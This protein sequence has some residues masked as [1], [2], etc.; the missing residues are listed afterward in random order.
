MSD[1]RTSSRISEVDEDILKRK[2]IKKMFLDPRGLHCFFLAEHEVFYNHW[3]SNR[4][5]QV[6]TKAMDGSSSAQP[7][8]F[9]SIDLQYVAP[10]DYDTFEILL[11]T[12]DGQIFHACIQSSPKGL[13]MIDPLRQVFDTQDYRPI[14]DLKIAKIAGNQVVLAITDHALY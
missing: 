1:E 9:R 4:V 2:P 14:L 5:F 11:G 8:P 13:D 12:E 7:K 6:M 3:S 10:R